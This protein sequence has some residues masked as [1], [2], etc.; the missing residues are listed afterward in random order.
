M[1]GL[2]P[3]GNFTWT[4]AG[5]W[6]AFLA[7]LGIIVRQVGPW[8][9]QSID[10]EKNFRDDLLKRVEKLESHLEFERARHNAIEAANRHR[11]NNVNACLDALLL[12]IEQS[13]DKASEAAAKVRQMRADQM[14]AEA[15]EK[16]IIHAAQIEARSRMAAGEEE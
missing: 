12:L 1:E 6:G 3:A 7:L 16:A 2:V 10:A 9:K 5:A 11:L 13:P 15:E 4:A 14:K 8:R